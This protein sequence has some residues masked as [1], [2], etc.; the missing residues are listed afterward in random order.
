MGL[1]KMYEALKRA[2]LTTKKVVV[3]EKQ[4]NIS[5]K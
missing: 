4:K 2:G 5:K 3:I 1:V